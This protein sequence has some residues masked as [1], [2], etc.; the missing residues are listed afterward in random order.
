MSDPFAILRVEKVKNLRHLKGRSDHNSRGDHRGIEHADPDRP[1]TLLAG[2]PDAVEAWND[3]MQALNI[4]PATLR[5]DAV[6][7]VEWMA[8][9]S[10]SFWENATP[11]QRTKWTDETMAFLTERAG[12]KD[13]ILN[14]YLHEDE[15]TPHIQMLS[16]PAVEKERKKRGRPRKGREAISQ[17]AQSSWGLSAKDQIG[18]TKYRL[19]EMQD[20]YAERM[21]P[22]GL[23]RGIPRKETGDRNRSPAH[24]RAE[25]A[26]LT[27]SARI[28][29]DR[30]ANSRRQ[31][32]QTSMDLAEI[33]REKALSV[34]DAAKAKAAADAKA[35]LDAAT[36]E[37]DLIRSAARQQVVDAL[38]QVERDAATVSAARRLSNQP[39]IPEI[40]KIVDRAKARRKQNDPRS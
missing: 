7:G 20:A 2:K 21:E 4:D 23:R 16:I 1:A 14:A 28:N 18:G 5:P 29:N 12:G 9:A 10:S 24:W 35:I 22:L 37:A 6:V 3:R 36:A 13:N 26:R 15:T 31:A 40:D 30:A 19:V 39:V 17:V 38:A 25:Q 11:E 33:S 32:H 8:T 34:I 27:D